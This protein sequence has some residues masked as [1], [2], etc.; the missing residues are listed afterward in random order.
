MEVDED[1]KPQG[2]LHTPNVERAGTGHAES[3][4][5]DRTAETAAD[6]RTSAA[7]IRQMAEFRQPGGK[8]LHKIVF[9]SGH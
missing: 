2:R 8:E 5:Q 3:G 7:A 1:P 9:E 4:G 6:R